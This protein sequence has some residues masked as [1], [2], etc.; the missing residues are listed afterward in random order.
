M[1]YIYDCDIFFSVCEGIDNVY[2]D[3]VLAVADGYSDQRAYVLV[4]AGEHTVSYTLSNGYSGEATMLVNDKKVTGYKFTASGDFDK[5]SYKIILQGIEKSGYVPESPD[6]PAPVEP[7]EKDDSL[8]I[9]EYLLIVL[10]VLAAILV[11]VVAI[12][13]MRS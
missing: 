2:I 12:R 4:N 8:G 1:V 11:V 10:V 13:M 5:T 6:V 3:G 9:T 7:T